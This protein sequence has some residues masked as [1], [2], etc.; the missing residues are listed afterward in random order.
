MLKKAAD[1]GSLLLSKMRYPS[2]RSDDAELHRCL[3]E[4]ASQRRRFGYRRLH[5]LLKRQGIMLN[6]KK[7]LRLYGRSG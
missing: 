5:V 1:W 3:R 4:L 6:H 2:K 7:L